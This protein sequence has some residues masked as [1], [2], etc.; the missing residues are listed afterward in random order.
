MEKD[1]HRPLFDIFNRFWFA[2]PLI[3]HIDQVAD[4]IPGLE[5]EGPAF[6]R[7]DKSLG[8]FACFKKSQG[9]KI[10]FIGLFFR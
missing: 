4:L 3:D 5:V 10:K 7:T 2:H 6:A 1:S 9:I 8:I